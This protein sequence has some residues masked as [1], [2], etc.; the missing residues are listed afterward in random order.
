MRFWNLDLH[1]DLGTD[2]LSYRRLTVLIAN[3]PL[4][5][6]TLRQMLGAEFVSWGTTEH[7]LAVVIDVLQ[8]ANWQRTGKGQRPKPFPRPKSKVEI[9][10]HNRRHSEQMKRIDALRE[11]RKKVGSGEGK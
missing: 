5:S 10:E 2:R 9:E 1:R 4:E 7:L 8:G 3:L 11:R 6:A